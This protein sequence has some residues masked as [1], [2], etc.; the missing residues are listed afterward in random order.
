MLGEQEALWCE[1]KSLK[2]SRVWLGTNYL[3][4]GVCVCRDDRP[5]GISV[6]WRDENF[7]GS[8]ANVPR[9]SYTFW[10]SHSLLHFVSEPTPR[11][12]K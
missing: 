1:Q 7:V 12:N 4:A 2:R 6:L 9:A 8:E 3:L 10:N 5:A 11:N